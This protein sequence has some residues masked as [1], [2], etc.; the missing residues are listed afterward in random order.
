MFFKVEVVWFRAVCDV[1]KEVM[2]H[3]VG[4]EAITTERK[5]IVQ[6]RVSRLGFQEYAKLSELSIDVIHAITNTA[7]Q[8]ERP[9][10]LILATFAISW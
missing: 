2:M 10:E 8:K 7:W 6:P 4:P 5:F 9:L 1:P 3:F